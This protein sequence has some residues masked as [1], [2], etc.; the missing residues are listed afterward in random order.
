[1]LTKV[2]HIWYQS[3]THVLL[4]NSNGVINVE[5]VATRIWSRVLI[6]TALR[7]AALLDRTLSSEMS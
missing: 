5:S 4:V 7:F 6:L 3:I 2:F 1:M